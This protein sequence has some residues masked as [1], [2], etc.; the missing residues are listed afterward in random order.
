MK[1]VG[2]AL[3]AIGILIT[4]YS[5]FKFVTKEKVV[6]IGPVEITRDKSHWVEWSPFLGIGVILVGGAILVFGSKRD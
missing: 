5:G 1:T 6:D 4:V 3:L 2:A